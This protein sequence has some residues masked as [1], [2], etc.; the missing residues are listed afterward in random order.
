MSIDRTGKNSGTEAVL[1]QFS[2]LIISRMEDIRSK[3]KE[4]R[5]EWFTTSFN[6]LPRNI[7][8]RAY[9]AS[10]AF[11]LG[12][13]AQAMGYKTPVFM[14][15]N[16][17]HDFGAMIKKGEKSFPVIYWNLS[18]KD[19]TGNR[20]ETSRYNNMSRS[21]QAKCK[22]VPFL[23]FY[24][25]FNIDQTNLAEV[26]PEFHARLVER[27]KPQTLSDTNGMYVN[28]AID[29]M[30]DTNG[31][32]CPIRPVKGD[33]AFY[34]PSDDF[35]QVPV[36]SQFKVNGD[37]DAVYLGGQSY[38]ST[39][40]HE[41]AHSTGH[42]ARLNRLESARFGD[43]KYAKEELVAE[44]S[45]AL[46]GMT[47]GFRTEITD[48]NAAYIDSWISTL[49][50]E[51]KFIVSVMAD[52]DKASKMIF[53]HID[54]QRIELGLEPYRP[55]VKSFE[56]SPIKTTAERSCIFR[57]MDGKLSIHVPG[58]R[59]RHLSAEENQLW[60]KFPSE[61]DRNQLTMQFARTSLDCGET[62]TIS[63]AQ[64]RAHSLVI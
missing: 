29:R 26:K 24:R 22:V 6:D 8:G 2:E 48:N 23:K 4:W 31:W 61:N 64:D 19:E 9:S 1:Q 10:N 49:R 32:V 17:A 15:F 11:L 18:I 12:L 37:A 7:G 60:A 5:K 34:R 53:E 59:D 63:R 41:M 55:D 58:T 43:A 40:L 42:A 39:M 52:V 57:G 38:Y 27:Y 14:T 54:R 47:M 62:I 16:Q 35:I 21:E 45:S 44:L 3:G 36:K 33:H 56:T 28:Q 13:L 20:I 46:T 30:V 50:E 25:V 51:P